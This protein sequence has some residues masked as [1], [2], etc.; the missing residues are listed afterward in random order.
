MLRLRAG[1]VFVAF[2]PATTREAE[3]VT[4]STDHDTITVRFGDLRA[5]SSRATRPITWVQGLAKGDKCDAI[6]RDATE[7]SATRIIV[8]ITKR[9]VVKLDAARA[10]ER[11]S[12]W[13]RVVQEAARQCGR[14]DP[15]VMDA[16]CDWAEALGRVPADAAR[17]CLWERAT[18]RLAPPLF[19]ALARGTPLAFACGPEGGLEPEE[20]EL[21]RAEGW[22]IATLGALVLRTETVAA[23][24]LGAVRVWTGA[25]DPDS[26]GAG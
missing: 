8:T 5:G 12:R 20:A 9:T 16:P 23:A 14:S 6:V 18:D 11:Q 4:L 25:F 24:V 3:A 13:R 10:T 2:D 15:P 17:F 19:E 22:T 21:A 1:D 7:L 26:G